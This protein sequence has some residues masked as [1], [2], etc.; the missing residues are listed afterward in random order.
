M[1][2]LTT[3]LNPPAHP[4]FST[5]RELLAMTASVKRHA[6]ALQQIA[7]IFVQAV[8]GSSDTATGGK[9]SAAAGGSSMLKYVLQYLINKR[10]P[11]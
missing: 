10:K 6:D 5:L 1:Y 3:F 2:L 4:L 8:M 11:P 9:E 7:P